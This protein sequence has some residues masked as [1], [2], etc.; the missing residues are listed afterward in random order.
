MSR[1]KSLSNKLNAEYLRIF[2]EVLK[3]ISSW[4]IKNAKVVLFG[5]NL[6]S[7]NKELTDYNYVNCK[8]V[9][10]YDIDSKTRIVLNDNFSKHH[11][12]SLFIIIDYDIYKI[13]KGIIFTPG[14]I[15]YNQAVRYLKKYI[16]NEQ[17]DK[18]QKSAYNKLSCIKEN[19]YCKANN[20]SKDEYKYMLC[21]EE[22]AKKLKRILDE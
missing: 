21:Q 2:Y 5:S 14:R 6:D 16:N 7:V 15:K 1:V 10:V 11:S 3:D 18:E 22:R 19:A 4:N 20:I 17:F 12:H 13:K 8:Y 9:Y